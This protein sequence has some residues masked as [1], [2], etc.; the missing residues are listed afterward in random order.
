MNF[1]VFDDCWSVSAFFLA[2]EVTV[3]IFEETSGQ[4]LQN[5]YENP[6]A[7]KTFCNG[8]DFGRL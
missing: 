7:S 3:V 1:K 2:I 8:L 6:T 4:L 5:E